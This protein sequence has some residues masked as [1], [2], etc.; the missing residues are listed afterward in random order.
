MIVSYRVAIKTD[1]EREQITV[2]MLSDQ[3]L[4]KQQRSR[5]RERHTKKNR[6]L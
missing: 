4:T 1:E 2:Q 5:Q 6:L 3:K